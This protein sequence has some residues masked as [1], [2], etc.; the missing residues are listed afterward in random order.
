MPTALGDGEVYFT[1]TVSVR[2]LLAPTQ[3]QNGRMSWWRKGAYLMVY[4]K[5]RERKNQGQ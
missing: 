2:G 4:T 3:N 1:S 5:Q